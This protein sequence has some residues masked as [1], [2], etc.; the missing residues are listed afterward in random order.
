MVS[1]APGLSEEERKSIYTAAYGHLA[2][3]NLHLTVVCPG[4]EDTS[5]QERLY[6]VVDPFVMEFVRDAKGSISA[7]HGVGI[8]KQKYLGYSKSEE[9]ISVMRQIKGVLDP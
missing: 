1:K 2:D 6:K 4:F 3:G 9:M 5:L 7:E 8:T